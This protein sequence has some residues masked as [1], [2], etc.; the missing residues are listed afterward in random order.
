MLF[1]SDLRS[2]LDFFFLFFFLGVTI[3]ILLIFFD[4]VK[5]VNLTYILKLT[6]GE[7]KKRI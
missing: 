1:I 7:K 5:Q 3:E 6:R 4:G 2:K